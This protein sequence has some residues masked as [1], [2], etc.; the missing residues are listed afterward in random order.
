MKKLRWQILVVVLTL[1]VVGI[2]LGFCLILVGV[3][4]PM[5]FSVGMYLPLET[6]FAIFVG[7]VI[8]WITDTLRDRDRLE[9]YRPLSV[10]PKEARR[11]RY[12]SHRD[13]KK[14]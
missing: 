9:L 11:L 3:R 13:A 8:R 14:P 1:I 4:S 5:L 7:G 10:D 2:L 6:T 12:R